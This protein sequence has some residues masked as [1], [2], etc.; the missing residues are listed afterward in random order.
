MKA[1]NCFSESSISFLPFLKFQISHLIKPM[2]FHKTLNSVIHISLF[3]STND[4]M[5]TPSWQRN[6]ATAQ[7][8]QPHI[9]SARCRRF[10]GH[11]F[12]SSRPKTPAENA[13]QKL[14]KSVVAGTKRCQ[15]IAGTKRHPYQ[16]FPMDPSAFHRPQ[17][18]LFRVSTTGSRLQVSYKNVQRG[19]TLMLIAAKPEMS[20]KILSSVNAIAKYGFVILISIREFQTKTSSHKFQ[21]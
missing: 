14:R 12:C 19:D 16:G 4:A 17:V 8:H 6:V 9:D 7:P 10:S 21:H 2:K 18:V 20:F 5:L 13:S 15:N 11:V 1:F 3:T